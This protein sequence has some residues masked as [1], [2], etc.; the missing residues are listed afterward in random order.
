MKRSKNAA[1]GLLALVFT[2]AVMGGCASGPKTFETVEELPAPDA[3]S[4]VV[5]FQGVKGLGAVWDGDKPV[6]N[7]NEKSMPH[8]P[9]VPYKTTPGEHYFIAHA[10]NWVVL[11]ARLEANKE[12][13]VRIKVM[14][15]PP[16]T[17]FVTIVPAFWD[18]GD[19]FLDSGFTKI[20]TFTD[21]WK[22][23]FATEERLKEVREELQDARS[24]SM[25][26]ELRAEHG[27]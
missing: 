24:R 3:R 18:E 9:I 22:A 23:E 17:T 12:Y 13:F 6:A 7:Y 21:E 1:K 15:S 20:I 11:R 8:T 25:E 4:A 5:Y 16:F 26:V 27:I 2:M 10:N 19:K 14:P